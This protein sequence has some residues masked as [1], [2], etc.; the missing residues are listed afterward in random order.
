MSGLHSNCCAVLLHSF[1]ALLLT[2]S[3]A[4]GCSRSTTRALKTSLKIQEDICTRFSVSSN[5]H[6]FQYKE[7]LA[8]VRITLTDQPKGTLSS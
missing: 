3:L 4:V 6:T 7:T 1:F 2:L 5:I 8:R